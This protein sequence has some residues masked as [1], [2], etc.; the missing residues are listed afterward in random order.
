MAVPD[1]VK[2]GM[3]AGSVAY[4]AMSAGGAVRAFA[5]GA[6]VVVNTDVAHSLHAGTGLS[7]CDVII[8]GAI[9]GTLYAAV[10]AA[11]HL[12]LLL[13]PQTCGAGQ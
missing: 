1:F 10:Y 6:V 3:L 13:A 4:L 5:V 12:G 2:V 7:W 9:G 11:S 8:E